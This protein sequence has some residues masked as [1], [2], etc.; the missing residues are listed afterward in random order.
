MIKIIECPRDAMQGITKFIPTQTKIDYIN[1]LLKVGYHS[2]DFGSFVSPRAI[3]QLK[4]TAEV[5]EGLDLSDTKTK[6]LAIVANT[7]GGEMASSF[8]KI[9]YLGYPFSISPTFLKNNINST[10]ARSIVTTNKLINICEKNNKELV[11]YI[12]MAFGNPYGDKWSIEILE[13][14]VDILSKLGV[15]II[16]LS[17]TTGDSI[18]E[19]V[20]SIF[21]DLIPRYSQ[22]EF[23]FHLHTTPSSWYEKVDAAYKGGCRRFD[24]V[25]NGIGGC[26]MSGKEMVGNLKTTNLFKYLERQKCKSNIDKHAFSDAFI[27]AMGVFPNFEFK[28]D[29]YSVKRK[30]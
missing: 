21:S 10:I 5:V 19:N 12:S 23:G 18:A 6:L 29:I 28:N 17:D 3:P 13:E 9:S 1:A 30:K 11:V 20:Y 22:I 15:K 26:P 24:A 2:I 27:K 16:A 14:W 25:I 4:D 8:E 7:I